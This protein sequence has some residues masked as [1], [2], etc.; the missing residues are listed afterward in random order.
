MGKKPETQDSQDSGSSARIVG[1]GGSGSR[2]RLV[3]PTPEAL[4]LNPPLHRE[5][6]ASLSRQTH[7]GAG[8]SRS[9]QTPANPAP[10]LLSVLRRR[11]QQGPSSKGKQRESVQHHPIS[12]QLAYQIA[13]ESRSTVST[14]R[15][16]DET[17][18]PT[19]SFFPLEESTE[20]SR[21]D[22]ISLVLSSSTST[23]D[24]T[25]E[26]ASLET[27]TPSTEDFDLD[28]DLYLEDSEC[29]SPE[30]RRKKSLNKL[31]RTLGDFS[32][33][34]LHEISPE[35]PEKKDFLPKLFLDDQPMKKDL[36]KVFRRP[37]LSGM[38][39]IFVRPLG[40]RRRSSIK[41][42]HSSSTLSDD[43][44]QLNM[45][46]FSSDSGS[47]GNSPGSPIVF[48]PPSP[49]KICPATPNPHGVEEEQ[50]FLS[51]SSPTLS[52]S[53]SYSHTPR[54]RSECLSKHLHSAS[55]SLLLPLDHSTISTSP[56][57]IFP[58]SDHPEEATFSTASD[59]AEEPK[60]HDWTG[61]WNIELEEVIWGLR[62]LR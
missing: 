44:H 56:A 16:I 3:I 13:N 39:S 4:E 27:W 53:H 20:L 6:P 37:S 62:A 61:E 38:S 9:S 35:A 43:L 5:Q 33:E 18:P 32:P 25:V 60:A 34:D 40:P 30:E 26:D 31:A 22:R 47:G 10:P 24:S 29:P 1:R 41:S 28:L 19:P 2:L 48:S 55:T 11:K 42:H 54:P 36:K 14:I 57:W 52:R 59:T 45:G 49:T 58:P 21:P 51:V 23:F 17:G 8:G 46:E 12:P 15:F 50:E 7:H